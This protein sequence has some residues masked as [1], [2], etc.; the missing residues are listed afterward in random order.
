M[1]CTGERT[2][3]LWHTL[4]TP[5]V[6]QHSNG[7]P[8]LT[9]TELECA[10]HFCHFPQPFLSLLLPGP[11]FPTFVSPFTLS[12]RR[13]LPPSFQALLSPP[14]LSTFMS[15][16][17]TT[18]SSFISPSSLC[19]HH[20]PTLLTFRPSFQ[21]PLLSPPQYFFLLL[22][23]L[24]SPP[25][26]PLSLLPLCSFSFVPPLRQYIKQLFTGSVSR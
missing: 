9:A 25:L 11:S 8:G 23:L 6:R 19:Y 14:F 16:L 24:L 15:H 4:L 3:L 12:H 17:P 26:P 5:P 20:I 21:T 7:C 13:L 22:N 1:H 2:S 18:S 10:S